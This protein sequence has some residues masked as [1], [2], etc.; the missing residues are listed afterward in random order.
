MNRQQC[1][2]TLNS[3]TNNTAPSESSAST[4]SRP[5]HPNAN[6][7]EINHK[8]NFMKM[9]EA[10]KQEMKNSLKE[11]EG[12]NQQIHFIKKAIKYVRKIIQDLKNEIEAIKKAQTE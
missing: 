12:R 7:E 11:V 5:E 8:N 9:I 1:K 6:E 2:D 3:I 10:L 4:T